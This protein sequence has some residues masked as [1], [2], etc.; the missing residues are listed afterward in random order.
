[1]Y[2]LK[3]RKVRPLYWAEEPE[4]RP[5]VRA[6]YFLKK[7]S[8]WLPYPEKDADTLEVRFARASVVRPRSLYFVLA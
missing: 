8:G 4:W 5:V 1:M 3:E 7:G 2:V 6:T